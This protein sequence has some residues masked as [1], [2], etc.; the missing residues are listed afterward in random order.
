MVT[1]SSESMFENMHDFE[2]DDTVDWC[3]IRE[4]IKVL[5]LAM[6]QIELSLTDGEHNV[7]SLGALFTDMAEH[8]GEVNDFLSLQS[9]APDE[10]I[11]HG[12]FLSDKVN[13]GVV[14]FQFYDRISQRL[15]HVIMGLALMEEV[16]SSKEHRVSPEA[17]KKLQEG[18]QDSY[19]LDCERQMFDLLLQGIPVH[20]ALKLYK[21]EHQNATEDDIELF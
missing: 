13:E 16:L 18:I 15:Q 6:A 2:G 10:V 21:E 12:T 19:S 3:H 17:W 8:L 14:A 20:E 4:S 7:T 5:I 11:V 9:N 1:K